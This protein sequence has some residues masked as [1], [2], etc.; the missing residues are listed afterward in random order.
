MGIDLSKLYKKY[1]ENIEVSRADYEKQLNLLADS[2]RRDW[3]ICLGDSVFSFD[4]K[5]GLSD[6]R[7]ILSDYAKK[8][9]G[10]TD[11]S[12][13]FA[14]I[15]GSCDFVRGDRFISIYGG[16]Y[17]SRGSIEISG[18]ASRL[19][20]RRNLERDISYVAFIPVPPIAVKQ[21]IESEGFQEGMPQAALSDR[22][23]TNFFTLQTRIM[24][25][26][27]SYAAYDLSRAT[28]EYP[29][30]ILMD[31]TLSGWLGNT[32]F[33]ELVDSTMTG[34]EI[35]GETINRSD[36]YFSVSHPH[37]LNLDVPSQ[38]KWL[39][40]NRIIAEAYAQ[41]KKE[42]KF[43]ELSG[44]LSKDFFMDA[45]KAIKNTKLGTYDPIALKICFYEN[46][47]QS[48]QKMN[49]IFDD[50]CKGL[51]EDRKWDAI[52]CTQDDSITYLTSR[53]L[54]FLSGIGL[55]LLIER[56]WSKKILLIGVV[57]DSSSRYFF[58]NYLGSLH[59]KKGYEDPGIHE[60]PGF[61]D[62]TILET[63]PYVLDPEN[64]LNSPWTSV[65]FDSSFM[66]IRPQYENGRWIIRGYKRPTGLEYTRPSRIFLRSLAQFL[67]TK[68][69]SSHVL[70]LDRLAYEK[71]DDLDSKDFDLQ[72][73]GSTLGNIKSFFFNEPSR[74]HELSIFLLT[75]L[76][77]NHFP[78]ALGYPDPLHKADL[79]ATSFR[80]QVS[81]ILKSSSIID[82]ANPLTQ[83]FRSIRN[84]MRRKR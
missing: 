17:A 46:P 68:R 24:D 20:Y 83:T 74:M 78:E 47:K 42:L 72:S 14:A 4:N 66:T 12:I 9:F 15:D 19:V 64:E 69:A 57:K 10:L 45:G 16:A 32:S 67:V 13:S 58:R 75:I 82:R 70:F 41:N 7:L 6:Y 31:K 80:K 38:S 56:C 3:E 11:P 28:Q 73:Y 60:N 21:S 36:V 40:Y 63:L 59:I 27:E 48:W 37:N 65:E 77:K 76:I 79:A 81:R 62:R 34:K 33:R 5:F 71:W 52:R 25:L 61:S 51:F 35:C 53:E 18:D 1:R 29:H 23:Y 44:K 8:F 26:A 54:Q 22:E 49:R 2:L 50:L 39:P 30:L 43:D 55:R 84:R